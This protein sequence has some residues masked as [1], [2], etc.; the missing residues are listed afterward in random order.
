MPKKVEKEEVP[1]GTVDEDGDEVINLDEESDD[2]IIDEDI[3]EIE[4]DMLGEPSDE[5]DFGRTKSEVEL[6]LRDV[7][8]SVCKGSSTKKKC[9][10]RDDFG[11]PPDKADK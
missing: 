10:V 3:Y 11:C 7:E 9:K 1:A 8:C 4:D 5:D 6:M 2:D